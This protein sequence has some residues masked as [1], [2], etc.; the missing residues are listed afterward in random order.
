MPD[1]VDSL[2]AV[3]QGVVEGTM[4]PIKDLLQAI[5][6]P[7]AN[8]AGLM[9]KESVQLYR[10]KRRLTARGTSNGFPASRAT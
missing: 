10:F 8:E 2:K 5:L 9:L 3:A 7:A 1:D 6:G 4:S